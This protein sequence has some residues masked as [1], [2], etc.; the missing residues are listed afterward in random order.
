MLLFRVQPLGCTG[1]RFRD[2]AQRRRA[3]EAGLSLSLPRVV[4]CSSGAS[5]REGIF[6]ARTLNCPIDPSFLALFA[7]PFFLGQEL[8]GLPGDGVGCKSVLIET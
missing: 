3:L 6:S 5:L 2:E 1:N 4:V 8:N 7:G